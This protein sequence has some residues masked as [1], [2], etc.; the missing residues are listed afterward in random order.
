LV[1]IYIGN[2]TVYFSSL[3]LVLVD[4]GMNGIYNFKTIHHQCVLDNK[5]HSRLNC[6]VWLNLLWF[7]LT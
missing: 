2:A 3:F 4:V 1:K 5:N 7:L 6:C